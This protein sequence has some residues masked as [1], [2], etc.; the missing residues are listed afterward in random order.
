MRSR[1]TDRGSGEVGKF[2]GVDY[3]MLG[4]GHGGCGFDS[5]WKCLRIY[6]SVYE[7]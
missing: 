2:E 6:R 5:A 3:Y 7:A 1:G 4:T